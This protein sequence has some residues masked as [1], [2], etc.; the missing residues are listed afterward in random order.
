MTRLPSFIP[1]IPDSQGVNL[2][3]SHNSLSQISGFSKTTANYDTISKLIL[4]HNQIE[5]VSGADLPPSLTQLALDSNRL[6]VLEPDVIARMEGLELMKL[7]NNEYECSCESKALFYF[8]KEYRD[9][10]EV[11]FIVVFP[12]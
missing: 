5:R 4:S 1:Q 2:N 9:F 7:G 11:R 8:V 12:D 6:T 10:I 3:M